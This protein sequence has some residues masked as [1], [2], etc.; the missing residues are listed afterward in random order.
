M[1]SEMQQRLAVFLPE[2]A[3]GGAERVTLNLIRELAKRNYQVDLVLAHADDS[4]FDKVP[5]LVRVVNLEAP[6]TLACLPALA[7]YL[8]CVQPDVMLSAMN[9]A[10]ITA[11]W[12]RRLANVSTK[13][14]VVEHNTLSLAN[15][16]A[17]RCAVGS[18]QY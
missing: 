10:S 11:L 1:E 8:Y 4:D 16:N 9:F 17:S 18:S 14:V 13:L 7:K 5:D 2:L 12:A 3:D 15:K 6:R